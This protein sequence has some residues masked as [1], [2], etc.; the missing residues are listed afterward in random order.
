NK[1]CLT[2]SLLVILLKPVNDQYRK[3]ICTR[4]RPR[5]KLE[6]LVS[7]S[8]AKPVAKFFSG[9]KQRKKK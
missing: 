8:M 3:E 7:G 5:Y 1:K 2:I 9:Q 6:L 4:N